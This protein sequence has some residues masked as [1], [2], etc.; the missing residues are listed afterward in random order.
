[1]SH[2][3]QT[4]AVVPCIADCKPSMEVYLIGVVLFAILHTEAHY[5]L[6]VLYCT[7]HI[8]ITN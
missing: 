8:I 6:N 1:M 5:I 3:H 2:N 7:V 4:I